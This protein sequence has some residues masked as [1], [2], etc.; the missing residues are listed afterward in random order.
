MASLGSPFLNIYRDGL[1]VR[2][3]HADPNGLDRF[4]IHH[5][6]HANRHSDDAC[7]GACGDAHG[8]PP[9]V[10]PRLH[11]RDGGGY[12]SSNDARLPRTGCGSRRDDGHC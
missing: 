4:A 1:G 9:D 6:D 12:G 3:D 2:H 11:G 5:G 7:S 10:A 8:V